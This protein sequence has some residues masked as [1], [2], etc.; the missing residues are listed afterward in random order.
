MWPATPSSKP[1][2][3]KMRKAA[4]RRPL[5]YSRS[6]CLSVKVGGLGVLAGWISFDGITH[7]NVQKD[8]LREGNHLALGDVLLNTRLERSIAGVDGDFFA[9][10]GCACGVLCV[11][12]HGRIDVL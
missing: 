11:R 4:A 9:I 5:R 6:S 12:S 7:Y 2:L 1:Y 8:S 3:P 10:R